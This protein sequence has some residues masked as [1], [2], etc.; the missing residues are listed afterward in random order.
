V[1]AGSFEAS[2]KAKGASLTPIDAVTVAGN[3]GDIANAI[4]YLP[5]AQ[6][7]GEK[8][9]LFVRGGTGEET[10]QFLDGTLFKNPNFSS[11]PGVPQYARLNPFLF[12][13]ILFSSG[14]YSALYGQAL[15]SALILES[16]DLPEKSSANFSLFPMNIAAGFQKLA[17]NE[18]SSY[19]INAR[20]GN[21]QLY[22][23]IVSQRPDF[24]HGPEYMSGDA[25]FRI[26][27]S[28]TGMLKFYTNYGYSHTGMRNPDV[29]SSDLLSSY[30]VKGENFYAT[31]SY[32][33]LF[34]KNWKIDAAAAYNYY[35]EGIDNQLLNR[36]KEQLFLS[37]YPYN[38]KNNT[39]NTK[40]NFAQ[41]KVVLSKMIHNNQTLRFGTEYFYSKDDYNYNDTLTTL[42]DGL[43]AAFAEADVRI[44]RNIAARIGTR[45]EHST[46]LQESTIAPRISV[47]YKF[48][49]GGQI[50]MAY[51]IFY[52]KPEIIYLSQNKNLDLIQATHYIINYQKKAYNRLFRIEAYYKKY[53]NLITT[54]PS[55][56]NAGDGYARGIE[57][58]WRDK[59]TF[60]NFDYWITYTY[61]DTKKL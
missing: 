36:D 15:S 30:E 47:A 32:R 53:K 11:V 20:Y 60:K 21:F 40:S 42:D 29:D 19:G 54:E 56:T 7:I 50:N 24:F 46:L 51:G 17:R 9:G 2:D 31:L 10:K 23:S 22:N 4:R 8:E 12:K 34:S 14:S 44:N 13:G 25:N 57:L 38:E 59:K 28:K 33:E 6:Q 49:D 16:V 43:V 18:K 27:T 45:A 1:S 3:G 58:F 26:K 37:S 55:V 48:N 35:K 52:Q 39:T 61:L 5:G 41:G